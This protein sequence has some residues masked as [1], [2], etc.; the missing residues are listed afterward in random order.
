MSGKLMGDVFA[1]KLSER[2]RL[3][4]LALADHAADNGTGA[5]PGIARICWKTDLKRRTVERI[6]SQLRKIGV[7]EKVSGGGH[8]QAVEYKIILSAGELKPAFGAND[9]TETAA[10]LVAGELETAKGE[11]A[12][13]LVAGEQTNNLP[14]KVQTAA[15]SGNNQPPFSAHSAAN[16]MASQPL[17]TAKEPPLPANRRP[18]LSFPE[19]KKDVVFETRGREAEAYEVFAVYKEF[20]PQIQFGY[21]L[22]E[23]EKT[24]AE[25]FTVEDLKSAVRG[26]AVA[27]ELGEEKPNHRGNLRTIYGNVDKFRRFDSGN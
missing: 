17:R 27:I 12:A 11:T 15:I 21:F 6:L 4:L 25:G 9:E 8:R 24:F 23:T 18:H 5:R 20:F 26:F 1:L 3:I 19:T 13:N 2:Q 16:L 10:N 22:K 7:I 14:E